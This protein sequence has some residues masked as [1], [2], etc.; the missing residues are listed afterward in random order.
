[1]SWTEPACMRR[2][3]A[4]L[5]LSLIMSCLALAAA[6]AAAAAA[7]TTVVGSAGGRVRDRHTLHRW[8]L[9]LQEACTV[10]V[11]VRTA[12]CRLRLLL[13]MGTLPQ[14]AQELQGHPFWRMNSFR[15]KDS[16]SPVHG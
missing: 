9:R 10:A 3:E 2:A 16:H 4:A 11:S 15:R 14:Q 7:S 13:G 12:H 8:G 5:R 6:A 1:M